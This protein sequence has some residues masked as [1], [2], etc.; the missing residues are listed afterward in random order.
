MKRPQLFFPVKKGCKKDAM[1]WGKGG[2]EQV[3]SDW[4]RTEKGIPG[5]R[6]GGWG[7]ILYLRQPST[8]IQTMGRGM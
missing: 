5:P 7:T 6:L 8:P 2:S 4:S 3:M 1:L